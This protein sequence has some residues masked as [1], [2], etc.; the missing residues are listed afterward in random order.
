MS[1]GDKP[2]KVTKPLIPI[3]PAQVEKLAVIGCTN[4]EIADIFNCDESVIRKRF[5]DI[6]TKARG[7]MKK[8]LRRL[9]WA[10][11]EE[12]DKTMLVW[13]GKQML[14][15]TDKQDVNHSG[16]IAVTNGIGVDTE[17]L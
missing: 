14:G 7:N 13:L 4:V 8:R 9:Q 17:K 3:D 16:N 15:Q 1:K 11:A 10:A 12:G 2:K 6:L 5:P